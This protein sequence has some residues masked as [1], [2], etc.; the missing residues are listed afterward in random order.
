MKGFYDKILPDYARKVGKKFGA[1]VGKTRFD[2]DVKGN[3]VVP[4]GIGFQIKRSDRSTYGYWETR[5][6]AERWLNEKS[7]SGEVHS[8]AITPT[9]RES[10]MKGQPMFALRRGYG[11]AGEGRRFRQPETEKR[12]QAARKG[13]ASAES[14]RQ[15]IADGLEAFK[16]SATRHYQFLPNEK[17]YADLREQLRKLEAARR[18]QGTDYP[19]PE[20]LTEKMTARSL[21]YSPG[22]LCS[23]T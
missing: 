7:N 21:I 1:E 6:E 15:R 20:D 5:L 13:V 19:Y 10:V 3:R 23:M 4:D 17:K 11:G 22:K 9:M 16:A 18:S 14:W 8:I 12:W 2:V